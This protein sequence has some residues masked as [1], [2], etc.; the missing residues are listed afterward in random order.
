MQR[1][2]FYYVLFSSSGPLHMLPLRMLLFNDF[3][4]LTHRRKRP[5]QTRKI[6]FRAVSKDF[7][8]FCL[9]PQYI[10][11]STRS[12]LCFCLTVKICSPQKL[13][14]LRL[15]DLW[16]NLHPR[17]HVCRLRAKRTQDWAPLS[18]A[19]EQQKESMQALRKSDTNF[20]NL[21][22]PLSGVLP[23]PANMAAA[24][25]SP[26]PASTVTAPTAATAAPPATAV[27]RPSVHTRHRKQERCLLH[28]G[29][30]I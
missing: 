30:F 9:A 16:H 29:T 21:L 18:G 15:K 8:P 5:F 12:L 28:T 19:E 26:G 4:F 24:A 22:F 13:L 1:F 7:T 17:F 14:L 2:I 27:S 25:A 10:F 11:K 20:C 6:L 3:H 23:V